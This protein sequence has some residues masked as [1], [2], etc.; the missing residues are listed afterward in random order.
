MTTAVA[1]RQRARIGTPRSMA[2]K[3]RDAG[4]GNARLT[5]PKGWTVVAMENDI[6]SRL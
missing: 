4:E 3:P 2:M 5:S 1:L 6:A